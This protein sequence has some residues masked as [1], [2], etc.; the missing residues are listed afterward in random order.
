MELE[1]YSLIEK[2]IIESKM[3]KLNLEDVVEIYHSD[4]LKS[5]FEKYEITIKNINEVD[6][7]RE[8]NLFRHYLY[9]SI[10]EKRILIYPFDQK[11]NII[12]FLKE[13]NILHT[14]F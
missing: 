12:S 4:D 8:K 6:I 9:H 1:G 13:Q 3:G 7:W 2:R 11:E 10:L 5:F 14:Y